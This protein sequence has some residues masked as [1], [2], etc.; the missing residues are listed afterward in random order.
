MFEVESGAAGPF[1]APAGRD[2]FV[3]AARTGVSAMLTVSWQTERR[4]LMILGG[5]PA[6]EMLIGP[7][8]PRRLAGCWFGV[9]LASWDAGAALALSC[10][11][12]HPPRQ[13]FQREGDH[14]VLAEDV[15]DHAG[16]LRPAPLLLRNRIDPEV[17]RPAVA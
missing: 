2:E 16:G 5:R 6:A 17:P 7:P 10:E 14:A 4:G 12:A 15:A 8:K 3:F 9:L 11:Q 1:G 13:A